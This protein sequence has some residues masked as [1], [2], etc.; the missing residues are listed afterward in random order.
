MKSLFHKGIFIIFLFCI[1]NISCKKNKDN[2]SCISYANGAVTK[3]EGPNF[4]SVGQ[5]ITLNIS[6]QC[7]NGC[8]QFS[9]FE[10]NALGNNSNIA[11]L[12]KYEGCICTQDIPT[13]IVP[14]TF[15][16]MQTGSYELRF[17]Q[18]GSTYVGHTIV[19]Q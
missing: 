12:A 8:G 7:I 15:K 13:R 4:A 9:S 14:Y 10:E 6:F 5:E 11:V 1:V 16:K 3:I 18:S 19:V 2:N 17:L